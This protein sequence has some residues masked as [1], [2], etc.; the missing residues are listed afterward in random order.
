MPYDEKKIK[1]L[2][3][4]PGIAYYSPAV[5]AGLDINDITKKS[6]SLRLSRRSGLV[7]AGLTRSLL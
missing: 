4:I 2:R 7:L 6:G 5:R 3:F 1:L